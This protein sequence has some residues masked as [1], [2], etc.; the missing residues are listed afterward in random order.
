MNEKMKKTAIGAFVVGGL[1]L[2]ALGVIAFGS[3]RL[4]SKTQKYVQYFDESVKG[5]SVGAPV[6]FRGVKVGSVVAIR[7]EGN[8]N[9][10]KFSIPVV[11]E[12]D[13]EAFAIDGTGLQRAASHQALIARGLRAQLQMQSFVTGQLMINLDFYPD[14]PVRMPA[15]RTGLLQIPT[16][17]SASR[18]LTRKLDELPLAALLD[19]AMQVLDG[20]NQFVQDPALRQLPGAMTGWVTD[21]RSVVVTLGEEVEA[22]AGAARQTLEDA[23]SALAAL[24]RVLSL[25][26]GPAAEL[27]AAAGEAFREAHR[28]FAQMSTTGRTVDGLLRDDRPIAEMREALRELGLAAQAVRALA[29]YVEQ[30][31]ESLLRGKKEE[32]GGLE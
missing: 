24:E 31:P 6:M 18:E 28:A 29:D 3:G 25:Q 15:D 32:K 4:F 7:L 17:A 30:H 13:T 20:M 8:L 23:P 26:E 2:A 21:T 14:K 19:R 22:V 10:L 16:I 11:T 27:T 5:L 12:I 9:E 1:A